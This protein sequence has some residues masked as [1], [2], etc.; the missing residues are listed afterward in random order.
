MKFIT[1][2]TNTHDNLE[3]ELLNSCNINNIDIQIIGK[4]TKWDGFITKFYILIDYLSS[5]NDE[6]VCLTD[7]RDVLYM[8]DSESIVNTFL[9]NFDSTSIVFNGD[10]NC[11]PQKE[12]AELHPNSD[13]KYRFL[14]SGCCIGNRKLLLQLCKDALELYKVD[15][16]F[17]DDQ[18]LLQN[19]FL[20]KKYN[21]TIDYDCKIFQCVWDE[22]WGRSNNY[23]LVYDSDG[24][25]NR[26][27]K[28]NPLIFH[29]PGPTYPP[30]NSQAIKILNGKYLKHQTNKFF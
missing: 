9:N 17:N 16:T 1:I 8:S 3:K 27:T 2:E 15:N 23:D 21:V 26:L 11:F 14:N 18:Y 20:S 4:G 13:K 7:S 28:T 22:Q 29:F 24:I 12:Y 30:Y 10:T 19:L 25:H 5:I 6:L